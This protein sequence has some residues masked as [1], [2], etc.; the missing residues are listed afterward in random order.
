MAKPIRERGI[1]WVET[2]GDKSAHL[3]KAMYEQIGPGS[4]FRWEGHDSTTGNDYYVVVSP[5]FSKKK[6]YFFFAGLR[7]MPADHGASGKKF[8]TQAEALTHAFETWGVPRP[9]EKPAKPYTREDL[10][11][12]E[13]I[14]EIQH[15]AGS[16]PTMVVLSG[17]IEKDAMATGPLMKAC[18]MGS[19][20]QRL[21]TQKHFASSICGAIKQSGTMGF[22]AGLYNQLSLIGIDGYNH[23]VASELP[24]SPIMA[25][26]QAADD[27]GVASATKPDWRVKLLYEKP[28]G[29]KKYIFSQPRKDS[30]DDK[31]KHLRWKDVKV[32]ITYSIPYRLYGKVGELVNQL[33]AMEK[34]FP[35]RND[36]VE[37]N[38][39]HKLNQAEPIN[40]QIN[41]YLRGQDMA[42]ARGKKSVDVNSTLTMTVNVIP[43]LYLK[44]R[45]IL[46]QYVLDP[47]SENKPPIP[48][49]QTISLALIIEQLAKEKNMTEG[50]PFDPEQVIAEKSMVSGSQYFIY[51]D[52]GMP[53]MLSG[54]NRSLALIPRSNEDEPSNGDTTAGQIKNSLNGSKRLIADHM[55]SGLNGLGNAYAVLK[56]KQQTYI[57]ARKAN[58]N[59]PANPMLNKM[60]ASIAEDTKSLMAMA[61][62][63][64]S[65]PG[66]RDQSVQKFLSLCDKYI[67]LR[68]GASEQASANNPVDTSKLG[69]AWLAVKPYFDGFRAMADMGLIEINPSRFV[70]GQTCA[71]VESQI[72]IKAY[73]TDAAGI[74]KDPNSLLAIP[75]AKPVLPETPIDAARHGNTFVARQA[76]KK[77]DGWGETL[78]EVD[79]N[80]AHQTAKG[81]HLYV[82][83]AEQSALYYGETEGTPSFVTSKYIPRLDPNS[84]G[85]Y[86]HRG[87]VAMLAR[88]V[89]H[90][91]QKT[92]A[93]KE[94]GGGWEMLEENFWATESGGIPSGNKQW[95]PDRVSL[96]NPDRENDFYNVM[97]EDGQTI[98]VSDA[99]YKDQDGTK[100]KDYASLAYFL[101][102]KFCLPDDVIGGITKT[103]NS[104]MFMTR[105][106]EETAKYVFNTVSKY[107][108]SIGNPLFI[109]SV[110]MGKSMATGMA[111]PPGITKEQA[112]AARDAYLFSQEATSLMKNP[113]FNSLFSFGSICKDCDVV[114]KGGMGDTIS[115]RVVAMFEEA[116]NDPRGSLRPKAGTLYG[117]KM[118]VTG[119]DGKKQEQWLTNPGD[120][121]PLLFSSAISPWLRQYLQHYKTTM[122]ESNARIETYA[123]ND[124][125]VQSVKRTK[126]LVHGR[127]NLETMIYG[128]RGQQPPAEPW[129]DDLSYAIKADQTGEEE[130]LPGEVRS[131]LPEPELK[132]DV[133]QEELVEEESPEAEE[134]KANMSKEP[135][136]LVPETK[137]EPKPEPQAATPQEDPAKKAVNVLKVM[138][139]P[140]FQ[141]LKGI[142]L[143]QLASAPPAVVSKA[144]QTLDR[145]LT[146]IRMNPNIGPHL[147]QA[148]VEIGMD[149]L[150]QYRPPLSKPIANTVEKLIRLANKLDNE[151]R[152]EEAEV[153]DRVIVA[154]VAKAR[155]QTCS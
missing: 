103:T 138:L 89:G 144:K 128:S 111:P 32:G 76:V 45:N 23:P 107:N 56:S 69:A 12:K 46:S 80:R 6:G 110:E 143:D 151:G 95:S 87:A 17:K 79:P 15:K 98:N 53:F 99:M 21:T 122:P 60:A 47:L 66:G 52:H 19:K 131:D 82:K 148:L 155:C 2:Y 63:L 34:D 40:P 62:A 116:M 113:E 72:Y 134:P 24:Y 153:V 88:P 8:T 91:P 28:R 94:F 118:L 74:P 9:Q 43:E 133:P 20:W 30:Q 104:D 106:Y 147:D 13:I 121:D 109:K 36:P 26:C 130:K 123:T 73:D 115:P 29:G 49:K 71:P 112:K 132:K 96:P 16:E 54:D 125:L 84:A 39:P 51:D 154:T 135:K 7:K 102:S 61:R 136:P 81:A 85:R 68:V 31:Y 1:R 140:V 78:V 97:N 50:M 142:S 22:L 137:T 55:V 4:Y 33:K 129:E 119:P 37:I 65:Q 145:A 58:I 127:E 150:Q 57:R 25:T 126:N 114:D 75:A 11:G 86:I 42:R 5:G 83:G 27:E 64:K 18:G 117:I 149:K 124:V 35:D 93:G 38:L 146:L 101:K 139:T 152:T 90:S 92:M 14:L 48:S 3:K 41:G 44:A 67:G 120:Q 70:Y 141:Q 10:V 59:T 105:D 100:W 108:Q 77:G